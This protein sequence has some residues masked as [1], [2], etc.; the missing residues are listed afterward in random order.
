[1]KKNPQKWAPTEMNGKNCHLKHSK[2]SQN[3][4]SGDSKVTSSIGFSSKNLL[5]I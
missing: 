1:V 5:N 3:K 2:I 4:T